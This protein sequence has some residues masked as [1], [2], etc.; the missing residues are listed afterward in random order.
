MCKLTSSSLKAANEKT[1]PYEKVGDFFHVLTLA[2]IFT[3]AF[4]VLRFADPSNDNSNSMFDEQWKSQGFCVMNL[5]EPYCN[6]HGLCLYADTLAS[7]GVAALY[8]ALHKSP[9]MEKINPMMKWQSLSVLTH[10]IAHGVISYHLRQAREQG[11]VNLWEQANDNPNNL[12]S[13]VFVGLVFWFPMIKS[14]LDHLSSGAVFGMS[15]LVT[16]VGHLFVPDLFG[17]MYVQTVI[18]IMFGFQQLL[19]KDKNHFAYMIFPVITFPLS[20]IPWFESMACSSWFMKYGGH[21]LYDVSIPLSLCA[22]YLLC[23]LK[24]RS[25]LADVGKKTN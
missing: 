24:E 18:G 15:L 8:L 3:Y 6:S 25:S 9:G 11:K 1:A 16:W 2:N 20:I 17:F 23:W 4:L 13:K 14:F 5:E 21:V 10:G 19:Q 12:Y 7:V 22:A